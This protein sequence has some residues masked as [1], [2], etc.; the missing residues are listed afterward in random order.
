[1]AVDVARSN[2]A[3][4][5]SQVE[6]LF[7]SIK[8]YALLRGYTEATMGNIEIMN[9]EEWWKSMSLQ[10]FFNEIAKHMR[11]GPMLARET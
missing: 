9:N 11:L 7:K 1:L 4:I 5:T 8:S 10:D 2:S 6:K 3:K